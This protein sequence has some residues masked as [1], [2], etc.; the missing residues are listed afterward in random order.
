LVYGVL[1]AH[2]LLRRRKLAVVPGVNAFAHGG[3]LPFWMP[4]I[5]SVDELPRTFID[6]RAS[7]M[8]GFI[9]AASLAPFSR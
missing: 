3:A 5:A 2:K 1:L 8:I 6:D 9:I 7:L 4:V